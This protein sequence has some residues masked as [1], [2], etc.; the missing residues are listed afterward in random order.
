M[1]CAVESLYSLGATLAPTSLFDAESGN[2]NSTRFRRQDEIV[3]DDP[4]LLTAFYDV[5]ETA[6]AEMFSIA[7]SLTFFVSLTTTFFC[8]TA[9]L[10]VR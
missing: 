3:A 6:S 1:T 7:S 2:G 5:A 4:V 10:S 8:S 9:S